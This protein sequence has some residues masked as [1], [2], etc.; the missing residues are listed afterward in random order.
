MLLLSRL[1]AFFSMQKTRL[2]SL[3]NYNN[4]PSVKGDNIPNELNKLIHSSMLKSVN[5]AVC[6]KY[7]I[8]FV[9]VIWTSKMRHALESQLSKIYVKKT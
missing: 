6:T 7:N 8:D 5:I 2:P 3:G 9:L 1:Y 4:N